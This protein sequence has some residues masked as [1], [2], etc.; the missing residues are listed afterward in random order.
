MKSNIKWLEKVENRL[1]I[2][3]SVALFILYLSSRHQDKFDWNYI[4]TTGG[5]ITC[6]IVKE[7]KISY[8]SG[9]ITVE[10][11]K[12]DL[13]QIEEVW[14]PG[15]SAYAKKNSVGDT[16]LLLHSLDYSIHFFYD[17]HPTHEKI[18][19]CKNGCYYI[20]GKIVD[21]LDN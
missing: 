8:S 12:K 20:N 9:N 4:D 11:K 16:V 3:C 14:L 10:Y 19:Q 5:V 21:S 1:F 7:I 2:L 18:Q 6:G 13:E 17:R 15:N